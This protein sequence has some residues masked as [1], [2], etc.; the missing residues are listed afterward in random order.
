M[1]PVCAGIYDQELSFGAA[2]F[3]FRENRQNIL[4]IMI[5]LVI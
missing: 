5:Y 4:D 3:D 2:P 1:I